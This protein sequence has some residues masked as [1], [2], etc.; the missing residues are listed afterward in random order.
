MAESPAKESAVPT[1]AGSKTR[2]GAKDPEES[3]MT[4]LTK[5]KRFLVNAPLPLAKML[6]K[7]Q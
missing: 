5:K 7:A 6:A 1:P 4:N 2:H 3:P